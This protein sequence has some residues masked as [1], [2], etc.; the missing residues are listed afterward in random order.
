[1]QSLQYHRT[2]NPRNT[3]SY[4]GRDGS[5]NTIGCLVRKAV[6]AGGG[7]VRFRSAQLPCTGHP[8]RWRI[9]AGGRGK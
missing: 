5:E 3:L 9:V 2:T 1:M 4:R 6:V 8:Q 7:V